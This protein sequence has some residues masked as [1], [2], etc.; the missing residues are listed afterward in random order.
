MFRELK[1][2]EDR[3]ETNPLYNSDEDEVKPPPKKRQCKQSIQKIKPHWM[4]PTKDLKKIDKLFGQTKK[5]ADTQ[6]DKM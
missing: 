4:L 5:Q 1:L 6:R 2:Q 3:R